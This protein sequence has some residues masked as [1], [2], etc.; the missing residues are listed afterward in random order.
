[1]S[2]VRELR[3]HAVAAATPVICAC[4]IFYFGYHLVEG[5]RGLYAYG[6]LTQEIAL[7]RQALAETAAERRRLERRVSLLRPDGLD[8]DMLD[9]QARF[10]LGLIGRDEMVIIDQQ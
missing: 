1:M 5:D 7:A 3:R 2:L 8:T 10:G 6:R 4:A 9:E